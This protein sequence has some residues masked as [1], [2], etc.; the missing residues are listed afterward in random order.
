VEGRRHGGRDVYTEALADPPYPPPGIP[1]PPG[2]RPQSS[3]PLRPDRVAQQRAADPNFGIGVDKG[4]DQIARLVD[5]VGFP[6]FCG[7]L[8]QGVFPGKARFS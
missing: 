3:S 1:L 7:A 8:I 5:E 6:E 2:G 4:V